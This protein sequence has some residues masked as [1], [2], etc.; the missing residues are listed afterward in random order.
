MSKNIYCLGICWNY[1]SKS[2]TSKNAWDIFQYFLRYS[3]RPWEDVKFCKR[4]VAK[5]KTFKYEFFKL[6]HWFPRRCRSNHPKVLLKVF[7][8]IFQTGKHQ[9][10]S[11][12]LIKLQ[13]YILK[14]YLKETPAQVFYC[15]F[16]RIF[17]NTI[18][19]EHFQV[20]ASGDEL[21]N[22][23]NT[24][25]LFICMIQIKLIFIW[26]ITMT[27]DSHQT[28]FHLKNI[29]HSKAS[30]FLSKPLIRSSHPAVISKIDFQ[31]IFALF[32]EKHKW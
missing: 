10:W 19:T 28:Q 17:K 12:I 15:E 14:I 3:L 26:N 29:W 5:T 9:C 31:N 16:Y 27:G 23:I 6:N 1:F 22:H 2:W 20:T 25:G 32:T 13:K 21:E 11:L 7:L 8:K 4:A 18:F 30:I 24:N